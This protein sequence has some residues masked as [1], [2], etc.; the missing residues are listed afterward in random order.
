M[1]AVSNEEKK[2]G[3]YPAVFD[4]GTNVRK[5]FPGHGAF[6]G[7]IVEVRASLYFVRY[8]DGDEEELDRTEVIRGIQMH[9]AFHAGADSNDV[10]EEIVETESSDDEEEERYPATYSGPFSSSHWQ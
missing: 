9:H 4:V 6:D 1:A 10:A 3:T 8:S 2:P 5:H 7:S